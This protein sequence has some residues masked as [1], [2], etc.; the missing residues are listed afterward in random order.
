MEREVRIA[1][2]APTPTAVAARPRAR[3]SR[4]RA[5]RNRGLLAPGRV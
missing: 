5:L 3:G 4:S 2:R 1:T